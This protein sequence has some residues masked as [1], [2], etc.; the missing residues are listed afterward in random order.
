MPQAYRARTGFP[1][2]GF[3]VSPSGL[4][5][6]RSSFARA[7]AGLLRRERAFRQGLLSEQEL[8]ASAT[9][10]L[11]HLERAPSRG[12]RRATLSAQAPAVW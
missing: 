4:R 5:I 9:S 8:Q 1:F 10:V 11:S 12:L 3:R 2:L 6:R 7:R